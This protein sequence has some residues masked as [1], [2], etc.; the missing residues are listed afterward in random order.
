LLGLLPKRGDGLSKRK[1]LL[2]S[3]AHQ[4]HEDV[5]LPSALATKASYGF[6]QLLVEGVGLTREL[7]GSAVALLCHVF[8]QLEG[9]FGPY[10][11]W[12]H[13]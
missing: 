8:N 12:W 9:F 10:T 7:C 1:E 4:L 13:R 3:L 11:G 5:P 2:F 6:F